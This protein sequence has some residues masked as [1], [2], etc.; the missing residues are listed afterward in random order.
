MDDTKEICNREQSI[1]E[2]TCKICFENKE[3]SNFI[4]CIKCK[5]KLCIECYDSYITEN[6]R[7]YRISFCPYC[8]TLWHEPPEFISD[9]I[10]IAIESR[11]QPFINN[12]HLYTLY[13]LERLI[14][15]ICVSVCSLLIG[16][17][18]YFWI[19]AV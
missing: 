19:S 13:A 5:N 2:N 1:N 16:I 6:N 12:N 3:E 4:F 18:F 15:C 7:H 11:T 9:S 17:Y 8:R 14:S 10:I